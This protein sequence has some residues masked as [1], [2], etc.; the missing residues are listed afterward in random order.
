LGERHF[1][2]GQS[3]GRGFVQI[4]AHTALLFTAN[5]EQLLGKRSQVGLCAD[6]RGNVARDA[7]HASHFPV[8]IKDRSSE[9]HE[10]A[11]RAVGLGL[12]FGISERQAFAER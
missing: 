1:Q 5:G 8:G 10:N 12:R 7:H 11:D 4:A 6:L 2:G 3:L 9:T